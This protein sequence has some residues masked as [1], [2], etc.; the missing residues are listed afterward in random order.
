MSLVSINK[1]T[2]DV[3]LVRCLTNGM[4][5]R[6]VGSYSYEVT[7]V[8]TKV[9]ETI[10]FRYEQLPASFIADSLCSMIEACC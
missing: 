5:N 4:M 1:V 6:M 10:V 8:S 2:I 3:S 9:R 7:V